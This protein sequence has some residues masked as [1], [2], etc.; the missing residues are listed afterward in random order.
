MPQPSAEGIC[1]S[2]G[3]LRDV[4]ESLSAAGSGREP[5]GNERRRLVRR[6]R[7]AGAA[8]VPALIRSL[9]SARPSE[10][11]WASY[12]LLS[13]VERLG[14]ARVVERVS[15]LLEDP[16]TTDE[17]RTRALAVLTQLNAACDGDRTPAEQGGDEG[18]PVEVVARSVRDLLDSLDSDE[19]VGHAVDLIAHQVPNDD[20]PAFATEL[21]RHGGADANPLLDA[22]CACEAIPDYVRAAVAA[23]TAV[24]DSPCEV[25]T[26]VKR[27]SRDRRARGLDLLEAGRFAESRRL[28]ERVVACHPDDGEALS[29]LGV[30]CLE[31]GDGAAALSH[32]DRAAALEPDEPLHLWNV[33]AAAKACDQT[34]RC[35]TALERY[36]ER[37]DHAPGSRERRREARSFLREYQRTV[38]R[39]HP[40]TPLADF[41]AGEHLFLD[42]FAALS[43]QRFAEAGA[44][45]ERVIALIPRHYPSWGNLGAVH[46]ALGRS[47]EARRCFAR[48]LELNPDYDA[49]RENLRRLAEDS[50]AP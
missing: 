43:Q 12:L 49:A 11:R 28:L 33:A 46:S 41:I 45:F 16:R 47:D 1:K 35:Y 20:I 7:A 40:D 26:S 22:L 14:G 15:R 10:G 4:V 13:L 32:L 6:V 21:Y 42:A 39:L 24:R 3:P 44:G 23:L 5:T 30:A 34:C 27:R 9:A 36:L 29:F 38:R 19:D 2:L 18:P 48:A 17:A 31:M 25:R 37:G 8:A 50:H